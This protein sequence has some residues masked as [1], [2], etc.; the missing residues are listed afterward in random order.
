MRWNANCRECGWTVRRSGL[1][2]LSQAQECFA[3]ETA[4]VPEGGKR[5]TKGIRRF[6]RAREG[7]SRGLDRFSFGFFP[8][9]FGVEPEHEGLSLMKSGSE[10]DEL[11]GK[12]W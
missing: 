6:S 12:A 9:A 4:R 3:K 7:F 11:R 10:P 8:D 2:S 5:F 1:R